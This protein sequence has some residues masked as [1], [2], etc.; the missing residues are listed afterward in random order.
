MTEVDLK[1]KNMYVLPF[2]KSQAILCV[3]TTIYALDTTFIHL[4]FVPLKKTALKTV[5]WDIFTAFV[6]VCM[7]RYLVEMNRE[8]RWS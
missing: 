7:K 2:G 8:V 1:D 5:K 3:A 6:T 4:R